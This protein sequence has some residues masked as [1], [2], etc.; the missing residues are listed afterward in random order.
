[1]RENWAWRAVD[2][3]LEE[4]G[5]ILTE[6]IAY[7]FTI[8]NLNTF[9]EISTVHQVAKRTKKSAKVALQQAKLMLRIIIVK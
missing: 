8:R 4:R 1:M 9:F 3:V 6:P 2:Q 5:T 7:F